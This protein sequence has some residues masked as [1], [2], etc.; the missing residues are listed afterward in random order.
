MIELFVWV[1]IAIQLFIACIFICSSSLTPMLNR[2]DCSFV[3]PRASSLISLISYTLSLC[4]WVI[5]AFSLSF[6]WIVSQYRYS[7]LRCE[8]WGG[9][10]WWLLP[11]VEVSS[12]IITSYGHLKDLWY[13]TSNENFPANCW[14]MYMERVYFI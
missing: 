12:L 8:C 4:S 11:T 9:Y 13:P 14:L 5:C 3:N 6:S 2:F 1:A 7:K 10:I